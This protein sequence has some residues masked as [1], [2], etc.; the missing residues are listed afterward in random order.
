MCAKCVDVYLKDGALEITPYRNLGGS[1]GFDPMAENVNHLA[2][3]TDDLGASVL[4]AF[5]VA[6]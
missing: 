4:A 3:N 2:K 1:D 6:E 5:A